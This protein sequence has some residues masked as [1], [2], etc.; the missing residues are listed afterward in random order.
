[1]LRLKRPY[2]L[3]RTAAGDATAIGISVRLPISRH[4][5][6][7]C[8]LLLLVTSHPE[9][10]HV[11]AQQLQVTMLALNQLDGRASAVLVE[12][13]ASNLSFSPEISRR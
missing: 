11:W 8:P 12:E 9:F 13:L 10:Q 5:P 2:L 7:G 1:M 6:Q 4:F 3:A